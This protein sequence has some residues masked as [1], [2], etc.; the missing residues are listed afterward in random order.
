MTSLLHTKEVRELWIVR[1]IKLTTKYRLKHLMYLYF[2]FIYFLPPVPLFLGQI[3]W[4]PNV[5]VTTL[6]YIWMGIFVLF[7]PLQRSW[8]LVSITMSL[9]TRNMTLS[10]FLTW[11]MFCSSNFLFIK[12][13]PRCFLCSLQRCQGWP[14]TGSDWPKMGQIWYF[15]RSVSVQWKDS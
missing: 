10:I 5:Y 3:V 1:N 8:S 2:K 13:I 4:R 7:L 12:I 9:E 14:Q 6:A 15:L 11:L